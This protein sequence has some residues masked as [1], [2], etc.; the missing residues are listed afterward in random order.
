MWDTSQST[1]GI[2]IHAPRK[3]VR[4]RMGRTGATGSAFQSTHPARGCDT[5]AL[6]IGAGLS[7]ISIHAPRKGVRRAY[8]PVIKRFLQISIHAPRKGVRQMT[9]EEWRD[10]LI[11]Q[12]THPARGCDLMTSNSLF[13]SQIISIHAPR[14]GVRP[15]GL[16]R[17]FY[18]L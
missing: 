1:G 18:I 8:K 12:S 10:A 15:G 3:G 13:Y 17:T 7:L 9:D 4:R 14:K 6:A 2:S 11:F 16:F 5:T